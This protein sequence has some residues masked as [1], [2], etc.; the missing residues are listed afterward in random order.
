MKDWNHL[1]WI[2]LLAYICPTRQPKSSV[3]STPYISSESTQLSALDNTIPDG[4]DGVNTGYL[5]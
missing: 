2:L 1:D 5:K 3:T 4:S